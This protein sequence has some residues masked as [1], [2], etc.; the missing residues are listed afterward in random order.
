MD[1]IRALRERLATLQANRDAQQR[2]SERCAVQ[3]LRDAVRSGALSL[4]FTVSGREYVTEERLHEQIREQLSAHGGRV[5]L[6]AL[7]DALDVERAAINVAV[8]HVVAT[9][10]QT[11]VLQHD[12]LFHSSYA[13]SVIDEIDSLVAEQGA[14]R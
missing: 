12:E 13:T 9:S 1:E 4:V 8:A 5:A 10:N 7:C 6:L 2:I 3:L 11:I 14:L